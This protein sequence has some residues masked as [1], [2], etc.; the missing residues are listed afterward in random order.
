MTWWHESNYWRRRSSSADIV[1]RAKD[2]WEFHRLPT[3]SHRP[4]PGLYPA[5]VCIRLYSI[6]CACLMLC[7]AVCVGGGGGGGWMLRM[8]SRKAPLAHS[9]VVKKLKEKEIKRVVGSVSLSLSLYVCEWRVELTNAAPSNRL[10]LLRPINTFSSSSSSSSQSRAA[11]FDSRLTTLGVGEGSI[12]I[13]SR[14]ACL[15]VY[16]SVCFYEREWERKETLLEASYSV[17][18]SLSCWW[19][20]FIDQSRHQTHTHT[21][22]RTPTWTRTEYYAMYI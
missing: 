7:S 16:L 13:H 17:Q 21:A 4:T 6:G 12:S 2:G 8:K 19:A 22:D 9:S 5:S 20:A 1:R 14:R 3:H 18:R 10:L 15:R 11:I